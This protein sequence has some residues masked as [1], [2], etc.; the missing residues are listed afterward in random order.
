MYYIETSVG[1]ITFYT[2]NIEDTKFTW[3][4]D[5]KYNCKNFM[6]DDDELFNELFKKYNRTMGVDI[7][8]TKNGHFLMIKTDEHRPH[9]YE[10]KIYKD[11][12]CCNNLKCLF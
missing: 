3:N 9:H 5:Y 8:Y 12:Y 6:T 4:I 2:E 7:I 10:F 11:S 1:K